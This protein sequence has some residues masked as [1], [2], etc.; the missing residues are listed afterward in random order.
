MYA[1]GNALVQHSYIM[2]EEC[3][4]VYNSRAPT[5]SSNA[6]LHSIERSDSLLKGHCIEFG[7]L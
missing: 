1:H 5:E 2:Y 4:N 3:C 7:V 6:I